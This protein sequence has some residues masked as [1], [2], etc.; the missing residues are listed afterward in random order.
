MY[1]GPIF[2]SLQRR[3]EA[4]ERP[5]TCAT[6]NSLSKI[7]NCVFATLARSLR[8]EVFIHFYWANFRQRHDIFGEEEPN[9]QKTNQI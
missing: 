4:T 9:P 3:M 2:R 7:G 5:V 1:F 8:C 6:P